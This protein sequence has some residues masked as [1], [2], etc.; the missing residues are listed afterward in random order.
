MK[1][2]QK[3]ETKLS[4]ITVDV[5]QND[6]VDVRSGGPAYLGFDFVVE[7]SKSTEL[8]TLI[9]NKLEAAG[10]DNRRV[11][12][13][14]IDDPKVWDVDK[15]ELAMNREMPSLLREKRRRTPPS[16]WSKIY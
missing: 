5:V 11:C 16:Q 8:T 1:T 10:F 6:P 7:T 12:C 2:K 4:K 14:S 15:I 13:C 3:I 9:K